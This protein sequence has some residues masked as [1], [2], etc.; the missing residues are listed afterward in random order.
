MDNLVSMFKINISKVIKISLLYGKL[1]P[2]KGKATEQLRYL[3]L[4]KVGK[5]IFP[6][7]VIRLDNTQATS[8]LIKF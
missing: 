7:V 1:L 3:Y 5:V 8:K 2:Y 6:I 4:K